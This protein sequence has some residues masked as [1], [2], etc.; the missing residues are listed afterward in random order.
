MPV[1]LTVESQSDNAVLEGKRATAFKLEKYVW[2][3]ED[4]QE[5]LS[6]LSS[7][8]FK[9]CFLEATEFV[10]NDINISLF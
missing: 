8:E 2:N 9:G 10:D 7:D 4:N 6:C 1:E 3:P 5:F